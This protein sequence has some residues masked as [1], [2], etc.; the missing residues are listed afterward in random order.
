MANIDTVL[1]RQLVILMLILFSCINIISKGV[2]A[3]E[4]DHKVTNIGAV[5][6]V[7]SRTGKEE[8]TAMEIAVQSF[9]NKLNNHGLSLYVQNHGKDPMLAAAAG[10][11]SVA[12]EKLIKENNVTVIIGLE[13][14][15]LVAPV[16]EIGTRARVPVIS[17]TAPSITLPLSAL[18]WPFL[19]QMANNDSE[20]MTCIA[21]IIRSYGWKK[22]IAI[23]EDE[24]Y[25]GD[26]GKLAV[27][28]EALQ[29][30]GSEIEHTL[31]LPPISSLSNTKEVMQEELM[32]LLSLESR[33]FV[34]L[35]ASSVMTI[36]LFE[37]AKNMG[38]MGRDSAWIITDK[39]TTYLDSFN[40]SIISSMAGVL[41]IKTYY[42]ENSS[43]YESFYGQF[44]QVFRKKYED[45]D[46]F[47]PGIYA[48]KAYDAIQI[49][50]KAMEGMINTNIS[51]KQ[52]SEKILLSNFT[53]LSGEIQF[54]R[55]MLSQNPTLR[56]VNVVGKKYK[57]LDF[58]LPSFGFSRSLVNEETEHDGN[59]A[60]GLYGQVSWP[61]DLNQVRNPKGWAMP[62]NARP[63]IIGVPGR[64]SFEKFVKVKN[65]SNQNEEP[66]GYCIDLFKMAREFLG[67][68]LPYKFVPHFS[69]YDDLVRCVHNKTFD[70]VVGDITILANRAELVEFTQPYAESGLSMI[71]PAKSEE[72]AWMFIKPFTWEMWMATG[73]M[74]IYTMFIVWFLEHRSN[75]EF[76][77]T[78]KTQIGTA[79][80]FTCSSLFFAH[81]ENV[82]NNFTRVVVIVWLFVS[83]V[84]TSS[85]TASLS[86]MLTV[87]K[88]KVNVTDIEFLKRNNLK[89]GCDG[90]SFV[91]NYL[92]DVLQFKSENIKTIN[93]QDSYIGEFEKKHIAAAFL[94]LPYEKVFIN[95]YCKKFSATTP[96][97]RF[98]GLGFMFHKDS[99]IAMDFSKAIL[100][101]S[102]NGKLKELEEKW[103]APSPEC[104]TGVTDNQTER[105]RLHSFW[106]LYIFAGATST[107]CF[108]LFIIKIIKDQYRS[109]TSPRN[110]SIWS[111]AIRLTKFIYQGQQIN[112]AIDQT[113]PQLPEIVGRGSSRWKYSSPD[114]AEDH[115]AASSEAA[116]VEMLYIPG[117]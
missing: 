52:L 47:E 56:I 25:G 3:K 85:Y 36:H 67:Y 97:Y 9:N 100:T 88:L 66:E 92:V 94:E 114:A 109:N 24:T 95:N 65:E 19:A 18:R 15:E 28:I 41:G 107:I 89:V 57:E 84:L 83:L 2:Q 21:A 12:A 106:G 62:T 30:I 75:P 10:I 33:V 112:F 32:K 72:S 63:L 44:K 23:Y 116:D 50:T 39:I 68:D 77:G 86:S 87:N 103:F 26:S 71:V 99:P 53:G 80:W 45:E 20:Q 91:R 54:E 64:T 13:T 17:F 22:V 113:R 49:I 111:K 82:Q 102:E 51:S 40:T 1:I 43:E 6:D 96:T 37:E 108:F 90:D 81:R 76:E 4:D 7:T 38:F 74:L 105:L 98:G 58:W 5:I 31:V 46:N 16:A 117:G 59:T 78:W 29:D 42:T 69:T 104:S 48:L 8:I 115:E 55:G 70:A 93:S 61:A 11:N 73:A 34:V 14:W 35:K 101:L 79:M 110:N 60:Q 27:L